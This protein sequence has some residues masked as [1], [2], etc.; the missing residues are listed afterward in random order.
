MQKKSLEYIQ[1]KGW[2]H[3]IQS[4]QIV[5]KTCPFCHDEKFH[6]YMSPEGPFY[7]HKCNEKGNLITLKK[8]FGESQEYI[9][10]A[11]QKKKIVKK[12]EKSQVD[13]Y[14]QALL[15]DRI[16]KDY[17]TGRGISLETVK[18]FKIGF[19]KKD[20]I[21]WLSIPHFRGG[22]L[23]NIKFRSVPPVEKTFR[24]IPGCE[25]ILFNCDCLKNNKEIFVT[26]GEIDAITLVQAGFENTV[27]GTTGAG[28]FDPTWIDQ[29]R[30]HEKIFICYDADQKGQ[31]G[32]RALAKRLGY[33][34]CYNVELPEGTDV[35]EY[36][37][38]NHDISDFQ[39]LVRKA[40]RFDLPGVISVDAAIDLL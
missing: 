33:N 19:F 40:H 8:H 20:G 37:N 17:V 26:E 34:R 13:Q 14:H 36:F 28:S 38:L 25:S 30:S 22:N 29:L 9:R 16:G 10:P 24:R 27:S 11:F 18:R 32:A 5:L 1:S 2:E 4:G 3:N 23:V 7:C 39:E 12:P 31:E 35:N 15:S 6:F 21:G